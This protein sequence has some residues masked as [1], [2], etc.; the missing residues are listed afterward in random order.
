MK[1]YVVEVEVRDTIIK[2]GTVKVDARTANFARGIAEDKAINDSGSINW[3]DTL[4]ESVKVI[5][6]KI[7]K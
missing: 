5:G 2:T 7:I 6:S 1:E 3:Q 4:G